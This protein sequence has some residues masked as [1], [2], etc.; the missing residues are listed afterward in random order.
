MRNI[1]YSNSRQKNERII[2]FLRLINPLKFLYYYLFLFAISLA[3]TTPVTE[4]CIRP[5]V[6]PAPSPMV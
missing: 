4:A 6:I 2:I 3:T 1:E 5:L